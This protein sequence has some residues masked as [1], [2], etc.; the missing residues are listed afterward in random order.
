LGCMLF[1]VNFVPPKT[2][3]DFQSTT[4]IDFNNVTYLISNLRYKKIV[5]EKVKTRVEEKG[6]SLS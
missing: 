1:D 4:N 2:Q 5:A 6:L 3:S